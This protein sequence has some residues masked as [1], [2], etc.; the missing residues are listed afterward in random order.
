[1]LNNNIFLQKLFNTVKWFTSLS[2]LIINK[3]FILQKL[4]FKLFKKR[5]EIKLILFLVYTI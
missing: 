4:V 2:F 3:L 5:Q 1:M